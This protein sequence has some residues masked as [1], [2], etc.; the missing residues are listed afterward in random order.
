MILI[1]TSVLVHYLRTPSQAI[2]EVFAS[3][4]CA[5][6]GVTRA[7]LLHGAKNAS[8]TAALTAALDIFTQ[9]SI[10]SSTWDHLGLNLASLRTA[11]LP[12]PFQDV[13][14]ATVAIDQGVELWSFDE[15]F[16]KMQ[17]ALT[18]LRL[19]DGPVE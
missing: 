1:D 4:E 8:D 3:L 19:F 5:V 10:D 9:I 11:G 12:M 7:E 16:Q 14:I 2:R 17:P 13:L 18:R 6:C 15:H